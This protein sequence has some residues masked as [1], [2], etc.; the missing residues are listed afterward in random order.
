MWRMGEL[1]G[2][3]AKDHVER[4][5]GTY[6]NAPTLGQTGYMTDSHAVLFTA[7]S[8]QSISFGDRYDF[9]DS[10]PFS[11]TGFFKTTGSGTMAIISK[12][13]SASNNRGWNVYLDSGQL[14][15]SHA[16]VVTAH[17]LV[18]RTTTTFNDGSWH[19]FIMTYDGSTDASGCH[20]YVDGTDE[21][22]TTVR[23]GLE[24]AET[25]LNSAS[26]CIGA[27]NAADQFFNG[28]LDDISLHNRELTAREAMSVWYE[29][30]EYGD[31]PEWVLRTN[32]LCYLRMG[33]VSGTLNDLSVNGINGT[34][35][36]S[37]TYGATSL[38]FDATDDALL[39][40]K[41][42][43]NEYVTINGL[44]GLF[45]DGQTFSFGLWFQT[46]DTSTDGL[47]LFSAHDASD[48]PKLQL[49]I[50]HTGGAGVLTIQTLTDTAIDVGTGLNDGN[51]HH[52]AIT[53]PTATEFYIYV[54][55][56]FAG[57]SRYSCSS[58]TWSTATK[59]S[60]GQNWVATATASDFFD[61]TLDEFFITDYPLDG[62]DIARIRTAG[63][64]GPL[65]YT[66]HDA[67]CALAPQGFWRFGEADGTAGFAD[68]MQI[69]NG[70]EL[71]SIWAYGETGAII[72]DSDTAIRLNNAGSVRLA[73]PYARMSADNPWSLSIWFKSSDT[74][75]PSTFFSSS[76]NS[77]PYRGWE[78]VYQSASSGYYQFRITNNTGV[79]LVYNSATALGSTY[80][81]G[82]WHHFVLTYD[83]SLTAA[84]CHMYI[85]GVELATGTTAETLSSGQTIVSTTNFHIGS[86]NGSFIFR[87]WLDDAMI[88]PY[89]LSADAA[90]MIHARGLAYRGTAATARAGNPVTWWRLNDAAFPLTDEI[91]SRNSTDSSGSTE[92]QKFPVPPVGF[93]DLSIYRPAA[94]ANW[95]KFASPVTGIVA[96]FSA[97]TINAW[98]IMLGAPGTENRLYYEYGG[99]TEAICLYVTNTYLPTF[100]IRYGG[101]WYYAQGSVPIPTN[102]PFMLTARLD[103][104]DGMAVF[105]NG[106]LVGT[107][108][109][110]NNT[111]Q[112][113]NNG[114]FITSYWYG[115]EDEVSLYTTALTDAQIEQMY[116]SGTPYGMEGLAG[117][118]DKDVTVISTMDAA[119]VMLYEAAALVIE[120][121]VMEDA[122]GIP[123]S[124]I[125]TMTA[126]TLLQPSFHLMHIMI[127]STEVVTN[128][129]VEQAKL[130][131][132]NFVATGQVTDN[133][134]VIH[135][136]QTNMTLLDL[137]ILT[138]ELTATDSI[139]GTASTSEIAMRVEVLVNLLSASGVVSDTR[140]AAYVITE[141]LVA[142]SLA[143]WNFENVLTD[144]ADFTDVA[145]DMYRAV[146]A[147]VESA[148]Y[149]DALTATSSINILT[150]DSVDIVDEVSWN[151]RLTVENVEAL[152][153]GGTLVLDGDT[154]TA[155]VLNATTLAP[156]EYSNF[157]F[158]SFGKLGTTYLGATDTAIYALTGTDDDGVG[159]D[160]VVRTGLESFGSGQY[161]RVPRAY[162]GY[163]S[164]GALVLKTISTGGTADGTSRGQ[165]V[166]RW[167]ELTPRTADAPAT[168][169]IKLGRGVKA[170]YWQ[171]ELTNKDGADFSIDELKL[172]P[173]LLSRRV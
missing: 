135:Y 62:Y 54:D 112:T 83:G 130:L 65:T 49:H 23:D 161:K 166:E 108:A 172:L 164:D 163:T 38:T 69:I 39:F 28:T 103:P 152:I 170:T 162:L 127:D 43:A 52:V 125:E 94:G 26:L 121:I 140:R 33:E 165:K 53:F 92:F 150:L 155:V 16:N 46:S 86:R 24:A 6:N 139:N 115:Y 129:V 110:V 167:Y 131:V 109:N 136:L 138:W 99:S 95:I 57:N 10:D 159:I 116:M 71:N 37:P 82:A 36:G 34:V 118:E 2:T 151:Q 145:T 97:F 100:K 20:L 104:V 64:L 42:N 107:N 160:A 19:Q 137:T 123:Q 59:F 91:G 144:S 87:G 15:F 117:S 5:Q 29:S 4:L 22:L 111:D 79:N 55:G 153:V 105:A 67:M 119:T 106:I 158:N 1:T 101:A 61:G 73:A 60:L 72:D 84:G 27:R 173:V 168:A 169:R 156:S 8:S 148:E 75:A 124:I 11:I 89:A 44:S 157:P 48:N 77:S 96:T 45:S 146:I 93:S 47:C 80:M 113:I 154:Y 74:G 17:D 88:L 32:P 141:A 134:H 81:N 70:T 3:V 142:Q 25:T 147:L 21:S 68:E 35:N 30:Q 40:D 102:R 58:I 128:L 122:P 13:E 51:P 56:A 126:M 76:S 90:A 149:T 18:V 12:Q 41:T 7:A 120:S 143:L 31:F 9:D 132:E 114:V 171:F 63:K 66:Y 98:G 50:N 78:L 85:D 14:Y 133:L